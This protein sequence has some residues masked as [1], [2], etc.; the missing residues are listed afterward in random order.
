[1]KTFDNAK[2]LKEYL[3]KE[4][5]EGE[6]VCLDERTTFHHQRRKR[7]FKKQTKEELKKEVKRG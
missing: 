7:F 6:E 1:M 5:K 4:A 3:E 2:D